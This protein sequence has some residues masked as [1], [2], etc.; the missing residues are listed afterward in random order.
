M[1][2]SREHKR[3]KRRSIGIARARR[4]L[5][6]AGR[7]RYEV[8]GVVAVGVG[9]IAG[10]GAALAASRIE[11]EFAALALAEQLNITEDIGRN[12]IQLI[13]AAAIDPAVGSTIDVQV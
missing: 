4:G 12:A 6:A 8:R 11:A 5:D 2:C 1:P 9:G 10:I 3:E 13:E 7:S